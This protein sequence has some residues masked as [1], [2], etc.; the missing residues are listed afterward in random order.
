MNR[1][2]ATEHFLWRELTLGRINHSSPSPSEF[3]ILANLLACAVEI[4]EPLRRRFGP[5]IVTSGYRSAEYNAT[6]SGASAGSA[7][8]RG[9]AFDLK[10]ALVFGFDLFDVVD[11]AAAEGL[12]FDQCILEHWGGSRP[13]ILHFSHL[14]RGGNRRNVL[15]SRP[16]YRTVAANVATTWRTSEVWT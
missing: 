1:D 10:P 7:H 15:D 13:S 6:V 11:F 16:T 5:I 3:E 12:R 14:R 2:R 8:T 4:L 9:E